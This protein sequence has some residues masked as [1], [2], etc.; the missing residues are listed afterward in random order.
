MER[1]QG[2]GAALAVTR[3]Y[4]LFFLSLPSF[5]SL[6]YL[7]FH[8]STG[9]QGSGGGAP[10]SGRLARRRRGWYMSC[11]T[12][13]R[14]NTVWWNS[15]TH[16]IMSWLPRC[17]EASDPIVQR[18]LPWAK[19]TDKSLLWPCSLVRCI[20]SDLPNERTIVAP[21]SW[22]SNSTSHSK[23]NYN[24]IQLTYLFIPSP[25]AWF[26]ISVDTFLCLI[27]L[28]RWSI[29]HRIHQCLLWNEILNAFTTIEL[30]EICVIFGAMVVLFSQGILTHCTG[31]L[32]VRAH[33]AAHFI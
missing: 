8:L 2:S 30:K 14:V 19:H 27:E 31:S 28:L 7:I 25:V 17:L 32:P 21:R 12:P 20:V 10:P 23:H 5:I 26:L 11:Q 9:T 4:L 22:P 33:L 24:Q 1:V 16:G 13:I 6:S 3:L 29:Q 18:I 15:R